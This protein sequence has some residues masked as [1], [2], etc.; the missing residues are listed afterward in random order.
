[1]CR[2]AGKN[3][4]RKESVMVDVEFCNDANV[5]RTSEMHDLEDGVDLTGTA[6]EY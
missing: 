6:S 1:M 5:A 3:A 4:K 2:V